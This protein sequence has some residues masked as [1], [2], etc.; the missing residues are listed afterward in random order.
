VAGCARRA[1]WR[2]SAKTLPRF[3]IERFRYHLSAR[4]LEQN[5]HFAFACSRCFWQSRESCTPSRN[6]FMLIQREVCTLQLSDNFFQA[7][8]RMLE[9]GLL[10]GLGFFRRVGFTVV[11][12][13]Y[14]W[15]R[16][17]KIGCWIKGAF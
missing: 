13:L 9:I 1:F 12:S 7:R 14:R 4:L 10:R 8:Q 6:S 17:A 5:F 11:I 16:V 15:Q 3:W 2:H